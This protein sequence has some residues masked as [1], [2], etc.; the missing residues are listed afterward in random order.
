MWLL[1]IH[2]VNTVRAFRIRNFEY[3][4]VICFDLTLV[5]IM[6]WKA[7]VTLTLAVGHSTRGGTGF[8]R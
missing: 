1:F 5:N 3:Y 6:Q 2:R 8:R 4:E 7:L